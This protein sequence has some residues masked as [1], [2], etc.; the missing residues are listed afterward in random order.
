MTTKQKKGRALAK[1][2]KVL[3]A[4]RRMARRP[5]VGLV[6]SGCNDALG[7]TVRRG[8]KQEPVLCAKCVRDAQEQ[9]VRAVLRGVA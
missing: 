9:A 7:L 3:A 8:R 4:K 6:C 1:A 2:R 5:I